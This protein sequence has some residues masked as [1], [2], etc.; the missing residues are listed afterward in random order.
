MS[1][2]SLYNVF[3]GYSNISEHDIPLFPGQDK[4]LKWEIAKIKL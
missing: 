1:V 3:L 2:L 4:K